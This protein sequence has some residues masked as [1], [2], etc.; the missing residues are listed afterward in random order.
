MNWKWRY[1]VIRDW[2]VFLWNRFPAIFTAEIEYRIWTL[3][4]YRRITLTYK[5]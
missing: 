1:E 3:V 5:Q 4:G 2:T